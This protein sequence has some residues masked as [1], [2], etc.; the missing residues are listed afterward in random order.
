M[1]LN[2]HYE[3]NILKLINFECL[4]SKSSPQTGFNL[5]NLTNTCT[6][7]TCQTPAILI[8]T[9]IICWYFSNNLKL[10]Q[11]QQIQNVW[12]SWIKKKKKI[13][14]KKSSIQQKF[15]YQTDLDCPWTI[16]FLFWENLT[17]KGTFS[18]YKNI[19]FNFNKLILNLKKYYATF[20][21]NIRIKTTVIKL[22]L[23]D[24]FNLKRK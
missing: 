16:L 6:S 17:G 21:M 22:V 2:R 9:W 19:M 11:V 5:T 4:Y 12:F 24:A 13:L 23:I 8:N 10:D 20:Q 14:R 18:H 3:K 7:Q 1:S 15:P